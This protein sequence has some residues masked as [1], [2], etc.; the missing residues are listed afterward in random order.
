MTLALVSKGFPKLVSAKLYV[1]IILG[2]KGKGAEFVVPIL[3][4][5][6]GLKPI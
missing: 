3:R 6:E 2:A 5:V 1:G 4:T